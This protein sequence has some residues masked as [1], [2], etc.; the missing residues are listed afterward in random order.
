MYTIYNIIHNNI[1]YNII[2]IIYNIY[3]YKQGQ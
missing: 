2:Y 3:I 1:I